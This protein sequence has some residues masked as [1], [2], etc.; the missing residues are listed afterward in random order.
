MFE[1]LCFCRDFFEFLE[2][3]LPEQARRFLKLQEIVVEPGSE[4]GTSS[5]A[6]PKPRSE[7]GQL[8]TE[9]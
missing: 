3:F 5:D 2:K 7:T 1:K 8:A 4:N 6:S 9:S